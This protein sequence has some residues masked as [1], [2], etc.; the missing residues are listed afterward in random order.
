MAYEDNNPGRRNDPQEMDQ[1]VIFVGAP[2]KQR[3]LSRARWGLFLIIYMR[4]VAML[5]LALG[6]TYWLRILSPAE[7][8]LDALPVDAAALIVFFAVGNLLAAAGMWM[9]TPWGGVLWLVT[10]VAEMAALSFMPAYF[11]GGVALLGSYFALAFS[12]F[13]LTYLASKEPVD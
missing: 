2:A 9:A 3:Q 11:A 5:W 1:E 12:Y 4:I 13:M 7:T 10:L 6:F 8:P